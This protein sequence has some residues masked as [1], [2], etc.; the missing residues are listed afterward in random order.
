VVPAE[1]GRGLLSAISFTMVGGLI[2]EIDVVADPQKLR[3]A[4]GP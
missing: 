1:Y 4:T 3:A 2:A